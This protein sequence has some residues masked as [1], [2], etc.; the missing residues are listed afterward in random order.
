MGRGWRDERTRNLSS[1]SSLEECK[2]WMRLH[3]VERDT[4]MREA[5]RA[6]A[7]MERA[8]AEGRTRDYKLYIKGKES[9]RRQGLFIKRREMRDERKCGGGVDGDT[10]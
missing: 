6:W 3:G 5:E 2:Q 4:F 1:F 8:H 7:A 10:R 9:A